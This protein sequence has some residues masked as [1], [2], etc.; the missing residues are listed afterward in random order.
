MNKFKLNP[1]DVQ[2]TLKQFSQL[3]T[4]KA[5]GLDRISARLLKDSASVIADSL[6]LL[7]NR[8]L[9]SSNFPSLWTCSEVSALFISGDRCD[10]NNYK[11]I[12]VL[13][14]ISKMLD[15]GVHMQVDKY[16]MDND[17]LTPKQFGFR[18]MMST[19]VVLAH[20]S[21]T[22]LDNMDEGS[23]NGGVFL[24]P[25]KAF[26]TVDHQRLILKLFSIGFPNHS[27]EWFKSYLQNLCQVTAVGN[28]HSSRKP[29]PVG[30]PQGSILCCFLFTLMIY[31]HAYVNVI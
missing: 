26:D 10:P 1:L 13:L 19:S 25:A 8:S 15:R 14:T 2:F 3:K 27:V 9:D 23:V 12:S 21:D 6:T 5:I 7:F 17:I 28:A 30:V 18:P 24:D 22:V 4:N 20:L 11:P 31:H 29:V 16:L